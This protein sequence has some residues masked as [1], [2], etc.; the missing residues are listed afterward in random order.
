MAGTIIGCIIGFFLIRIFNK[1]RVFLIRKSDKFIEA[2]KQID[3]FLVRK[4]YNTFGFN[5][6]DI[7]KY[8]PELDEF[9][10]S[11]L[12][13]QVKDN[14]NHKMMKMN[15][16][17]DAINDIEQI[18]IIKFKQTLENIKIQKSLENID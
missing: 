7:I 1:I 18:D 4:F 11:K 9:I 8:A 12:R 5:Y 14:V 13:L 2:K 17:Y 15:E 6:E 16:I 3:D 10:S